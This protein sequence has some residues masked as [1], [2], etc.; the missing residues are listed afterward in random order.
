MPCHVYVQLARLEKA[1][2]WRFMAEMAGFNARQVRDRLGMAAG[3]GCALAAPVAS[4][5]KTVWVVPDGD[6]R[7]IRGDS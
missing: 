2:W 7:N 1:A 5:E 4:Q 3:A 6:L